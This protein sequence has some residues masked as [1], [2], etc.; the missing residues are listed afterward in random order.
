[1][2]TLSGLVFS[3]VFALVQF[4]S[5]SYSP[6]LTRIFAHSYA[7]R[8]SLGVF[9]GTFLYSLMAM[10]SFG[11]EES[12]TSGL[13]VW[14]AFIWLLLSIAVLALLIKVFTTMT[15]SNTLR[16]LS[17]LG[18][19]SIAHIYS[20]RSNQDAAHKSDDTNFIIN[21]QHSQRIIYNGSP[22]Y[23]VGYN[24]GKLSKIA[25]K[26]G[27]VIFLPYFIGDVVRSGSELVI[28]Q[29]ENI[30]LPE[31]SVL[32]SI[33]MDI[34]RAFKN[35][36]K[37]SFRLLVDTAIRALSP[38]INDPTTAVQV[39]D[40]LESLLYQLGKSNLNISESSDTNR[41]GRVVFK[42]PDWQDYLQLGLTEIMQYGATSIQVQRRLK[43]LLLF[44]KS[45]VPENLTDAVEVF[46]NMQDSL[47]QQSF[48]FD[49]FRQMAR[50][51]DR[52][53]IGSY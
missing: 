52:E 6:R 48:T 50:V 29:G 30:P 46:L 20:Q 42:S 36:P 51:S 25:Q 35:D 34:E 2:I 40:H 22:G 44:L 3:L 8:H 24:I 9:T 41:T 14:I 43:A 5:A 27:T 38:A 53:G 31:S 18:R 49:S 45:N 32:N 39:L 13:A 1:M 17:S 12:K 15:I 21:K 47:I 7:L 37:Y 23:V 26:T 16:T 28:I 10:R 33:Q 11:L 19:S 4:G